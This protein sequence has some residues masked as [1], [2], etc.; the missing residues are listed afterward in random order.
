M[1]IHLVTQIDGEEFRITLSHD[2][3]GNYVAEAVHL[4]GGEA[5]ERHAPPHVRVVDP[6]KERAVRALFASLRRLVDERRA[7][8][9]RRGPDAPAAA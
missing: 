3:A 2:D 7:C 5:A 4:A 6:A 9:P 1:A 8:D